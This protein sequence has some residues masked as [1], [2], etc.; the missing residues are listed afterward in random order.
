MY[1]SKPRLA[2]PPG[3]LVTTEEMKS[4]L[5]IDFSDDDAQ[6]ASFVAAATRRLDGYSGI[7]G[8]CLLTQGWEINLRTWP[9]SRLRLPF[10]D[11]TGVEVEYADA[12]G[13]NQIIPESQFELVEGAQGTELVLRDGFS[14][15]ALSKAV[16]LPVK[17]TIT[18]GYGAVAD[19]PSPIRVAVMMLAAHWYENRADGAGGSE[20]PFGVS[21]LIAPYRLVG[22]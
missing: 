7:L 21:A 8:R 3:A 15:P 2:T 6:I 5:M 20:M 12:D 16:E 10:P 4:H 1:A 17:L 22:L 13:Q 11:V 14:A 9:N 18:A 19:V